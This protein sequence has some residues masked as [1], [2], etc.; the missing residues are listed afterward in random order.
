MHLHSHFLA[1]LS[2]ISL[3][4]LYVKYFIWKSSLN[5]VKLYVH[6]EI[7]KFFTHYRSGDQQ[8]MPQ[9][10]IQTQNHVF[11]LWGGIKDH[12]T[13]MSQSISWYTACIIPTTSYWSESNTSCTTI[14]RNEGLIFQ[15]AW[16]CSSAVVRDWKHFF[17]AANCTEVLQ[18]TD[19]YWK[20][21]Y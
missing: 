11:F 16:T 12:C 4:I 17:M 1:K 13:A 6:G 18:N 8:S 20:V 9:E 10:I 21:I 15:D 14:S 5:E 7:E 19:F 3:I 2:K